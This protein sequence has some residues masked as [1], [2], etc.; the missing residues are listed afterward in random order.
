L[1]DLVRRRLAYYD[2]VEEMIGVCGGTDSS[3]V[4][5]GS[6][7]LQPV[8]ARAAASASLGRRHEARYP[9]GAGRRANMTRATRGFAACHYCGR[10]GDGCATSSFFNSADHLLPFALETGKLEIRSNAVAARVL[11]DDRGLAKGVQYF[12]RKTGVEQEIL[13]KV[14]V[15]GASCM[16][17]TRIC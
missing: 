14:V 8:P 12:D 10:C 2:K 7:F 1:A 4:L 5:P 9:H 3:E 17:S 16:D 15:V 11:V 6:K 13:A